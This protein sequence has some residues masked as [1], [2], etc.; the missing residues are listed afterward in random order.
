MMNVVMPD[1]SSKPTHDPTGLHETGR[2][3]RR[4][5]VGPTSRVV[6]THARK[7][8]LRIKQV[9]ADG[10]RKYIYSLQQEQAIPEGI[11]LADALKEYE[12]RVHSP[13]SRK[14]LE[15]EKSGL[16]AARDSAVVQ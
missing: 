7:I 9:R 16:V 12:R 2:L 10:A 15:K 13:E 8:V 6:E 3:H 5:F 4:F 11:S 14:V 1:I